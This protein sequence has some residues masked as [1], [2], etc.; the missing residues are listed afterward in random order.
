MPSRFQS[1][2]ALV[3]RLLLCLIFLHSALGKLSNPKGTIAAMQS[4]GMPLAPAGLPL[5][6]AGETLGGLALLLGFRARIGAGVL[7]VFLVP[8]T[9]YFHNF[10]TYPAAEQHVQMI[11]FMK[12]IT[13]IG[14]LLMVVAFGPG[15][16]SLDA[17]RT[18]CRRAAAA[19]AQR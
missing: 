1:S 11:Q 10:W 3:G 15:G 5:A 19:P 12:N 7:A 4:R 13:I 18:C 14:G 17:C 2:A 8:T 6:I 16:F 9:L